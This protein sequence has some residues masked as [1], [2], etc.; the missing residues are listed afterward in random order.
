[1]VV[2]RR[3]GERHIEHRVSSARLSSANPGTCTTAL[4]SPPQSCGRRRGGGETDTAVGRVAVRVAPR[5]DAEG[6]V[7][8]RVQ[9][10]RGT[11]AEV[12]PRR[13]VE[14]GDGGNRGGVERL[15]GAV[16]DCPHCCEGPACA[17]GH[18]D[19]NA[20]AVVRPGLPVPS[21]PNAPNPSI[22]VDAYRYRVGVGF[23]GRREGTAVYEIDCGKAR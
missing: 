4:P 10:R 3:G 21:G 16:E 11:P 18:G 1:M 13:R 17:S 22:I 20:N 14:A 12:V 8:G 9:R 15:L 7:E 5:G 23:A 2:H 6:E 19:S